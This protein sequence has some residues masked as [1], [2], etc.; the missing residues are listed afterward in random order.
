[1]PHLKRAH[2][3][4]LTIALS[5]GA[6]ADGNAELGDSSAVMASMT[7]PDGAE[8]VSF[9]GETL[10]PPEQPEAVR[11]V[12][13]ERYAEAEDALIEAPQ[14]ADALVWMGRR[15]AYLGEY[16]SAIEIYTHALTLHPMDAR[17]YRHRGH[18]Y[19]TVR[20]LDRAIADLQRGLELVSGLPDEVELDGLPNRLNIPTST[21]HF[22]LWYHL[23][24]SHY[25][26]G[27]LEAALEAQRSC[28]AVSLHPDS[29]V[30]ASYWLY[31]TLRRLGMGDEAAAVLGGISADMEIIESTGYLDLLL[32]YKGERT[33]E[34]LMGPAGSDATLQST[35][36][37]YGLGVWYLLNDR[38]NEAR[39]TWER[40][41]TG[42]SQWPAFGYLAAE[43]EL[44]R[45]GAE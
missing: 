35:T 8:A 17:L 13:L 15:T 6:C 33:L 23:A 5:M 24:L 26:K 32:L 41:L 3:I 38:P 18:R 36:T 22:N 4:S 1:M 31:M 16:R 39:E 9:L 14:G 45:L 28:L 21:L 34:D 42:R 11:A 37:A 19:L 44:A 20:D 12:Y 30:A 10:M 29:V 25:V 7:L 27:D 2:F 40:I 43:S